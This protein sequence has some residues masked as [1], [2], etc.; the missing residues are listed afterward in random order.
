MVFNGKDSHH[1]FLSAN[2]WLRELIILIQEFIKGVTTKTESAAIH[3]TV[4]KIDLFSWPW[5]LV[6]SFSLCSMGIFLCLYNF[7]SRRAAK[8]DTHQITAIV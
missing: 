7:N 6:L 2:N 1:L 8:H 4:F 5:A 3:A